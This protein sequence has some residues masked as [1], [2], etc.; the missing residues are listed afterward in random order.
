MEQTCNEIT[1]PA[2]L[3]YGLGVRS[4][5]QQRQSEWEKWNCDSS[6]PSCEVLRFRDGPIMKSFLE[7]VRL[8]LSL[9]GWRESEKVTRRCQGGWRNPSDSDPTPRALHPVPGC[10]SLGWR[11]SKLFLA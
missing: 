8:A 1:Y 7:E 10:T 6:S 9:K 4:G 5:P 3:C 2:W 11:E